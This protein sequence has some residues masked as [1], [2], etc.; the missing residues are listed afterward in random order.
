MFPWDRV[1][2]SARF[3]AAVARLE[4]ALVAA[5]GLGQR[6]HELVDGALHRPWHARHRRELATALMTAAKQFTLS[7]QTRK[8]VQGLDQPVQLRVFARADDFPRFRERLSEYE[9]ASDKVKVE[10]VDVARAIPGGICP[11]CGKPSL[12]I[13]N[14]IEVGNIFQLG[15]RYSDALDTADNHVVVKQCIG[16]RLG[17]GDAQRMLDQL[18]ALHVLLPQATRFGSFALVRLAGSRRDRPRS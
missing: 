11:V 4:S 12:R 16:R 13:S 17:C 15:T 9:Y 7:D 5:R 1:S 10:Y 14:G 2:S 18:H 6:A 8:V 3:S